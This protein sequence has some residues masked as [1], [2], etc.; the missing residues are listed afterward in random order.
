MRKLIINVTFAVLFTFSIGLTVGFLNSQAGE[1][2]S[3]KQLANPFPPPPSPSDVQ[4][5][6]NDWARTDTLTKLNEVVD[7]LKKLRGEMRK[8]RKHCH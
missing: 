5:L 1:Q 2:L 3:D 7:E 6:M 4:A 8:L